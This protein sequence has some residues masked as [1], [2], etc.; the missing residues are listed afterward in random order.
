[1]QSGLYYQ[2][3]V[4]LLMQKYC[5]GNL[6][7]HPVIEIGEPKELWYKRSQGFLTPSSALTQPG[8]YIPGIEIQ[9]HA[10]LKR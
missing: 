9:L 6:L 1:M 10:A 7:L 5:H 3:N 8:F 2:G 4:L